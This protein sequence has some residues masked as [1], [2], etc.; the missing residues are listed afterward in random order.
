MVRR[1]LRLQGKDADL[2]PVL[3]SSAVADVQK[4]RRTAP[5]KK[6]SELTV[7]DPDTAVRSSTRAVKKPKD[8]SRRVKG[9][10]ERLC[11]EIPNEIFLE[12]LKFLNPIDLLHLARTNKELRSILMCRSS[13]S[14]WRAARENVAGLPALPSDLE[15]PQYASLLFD[16]HCHI[17]LEKPCLN[18]IWQCRIRCHKACESKVFGTSNEILYREER[19]FQ[20]HKIVKYLPVYKTSSHNCT[21]LISAFKPLHH[22]YMEVKDDTAKLNQWNEKQACRRDEMIRHGLECQRWLKEGRSQRRDEQKTLRSRRR[23]EITKRLRKLGWDNHELENP[24][25]LSHRHVAQAKVLIDHE[26]NVI[27]PPLIRLL[28]D[29]KRSRLTEDSGAVVRERY[30]LLQNTYEAYCTDTLQVHDG[31]APPIGDVALLPEFN[32]TALQKMIQK[33]PLDRRLT[34]PDFTK[35][36]D[37]DL[38]DI[39]KGWMADKG[40]QL[41]EIARQGDGKCDLR[42]VVFKCNLCSESLWIPRVYGHRCLFESPL[43]PFQLPAHKPTGK[44][45]F[46]PFEDSVLHWRQ[47]ST[48]LLVYSLC[49]TWYAKTVLDLCG[50]NMTSCSLEDLEEVDPLLECLDCG[51]SVGDNTESG[52]RL[53]MRWVTAVSAVNDFSD[54]PE[55]IL[56]PVSSRFFTLTLTIHFRSP[57]LTAK[58]KPGSERECRT[59]TFPC[60]RSVVS[61]VRLRLHATGAWTRRLLSGNIWKISEQ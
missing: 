19:Y 49:E 35:A 31:V 20:G 17:C 26:W 30:Q 15:E 41:R 42:S 9:R 24:A 8:L 58:L 10:L 4:L 54:H 61:S 21:Y 38:A 7:D 23:D 55:L 27:K 12:I 18:V 47:W 60:Q 40:V 50:M 43:N 57:R 48:K 44:S 6:S 56:E 28:E 34:A 45:C 59:G 25:F 53:F 14:S 46:D 3:P 13:S 2:V 36:F 51:N 5:N 39:T 22:Q 29:L 37:F 16:T 32:F 52:G 1:S 11:E 33:I